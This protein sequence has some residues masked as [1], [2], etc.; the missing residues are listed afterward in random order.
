MMLPTDSTVFRRPIG[1]RY[2]AAYWQHYSTQQKPGSKTRRRLLGRRQGG[3]SP[4]SKAGGISSLEERYSPPPMGDG[5]PEGGMNWGEG[6]HL[7]S[8]GCGESANCES[9][10][11]TSP[12]GEIVADGQSGR[13]AVPSRGTA[14]RI[15]HSCCC[16][17]CCVC[18]QV[19]KTCSLGTG[20][21]PRLSTPRR[22][23][24]RAPSVPARAA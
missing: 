3:G 22:P 4:P 12:R 8:S 5:S 13:S 6:T 23:A 21:D 16:H 2:C 19:R 18:T 1:W 9:R 10:L 24:W 7:A 14:F 11:R 15:A 20:D 17:D